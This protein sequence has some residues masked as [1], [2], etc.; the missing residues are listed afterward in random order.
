MAV[1]SASDVTI[2]LSITALPNSGTAKIAVLTS[3]TD[4]NSHSYTFNSIAG[5]E[6]TFDENSNVY[7]LVQ[8]AFETDS[9]NGQ[10]EVIVAPSSD[11]SAGSTTTSTSTTSTTS[12]SSSSSSSSSSTTT[13]RF[14]YALKQYIND[15]FNYIVDDNLKE[16]DLEAVTD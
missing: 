3:G 5:V 14:V 16:S 7:N 13:N 8:K 6:D 15:G 1:K 4:S 2:N 9:Y 11:V 10:V 12:T